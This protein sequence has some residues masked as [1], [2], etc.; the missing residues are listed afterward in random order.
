[1]STPDLDGIYSVLFDTIAE[2]L[3]IVDVNGK[4]VM[5]NPQACEMFL[6]DKDTIIGVQVEQLIPMPS[7]E[8]HVKLREGYVQDPHKRQMGKNLNLQAVKK[9]GTHFDVEISL[10]HFM[11]N[12]SAYVVAML[13]DITDRVAQQKQIRELNE[14][15]EQKV[16]E[17][18]RQVLESQKLYSAIAQNF[19]NGTINVF[20]RDLKYLFVEGLELQELGVAKEKLIGTSYLDKISQDIRPYIETELT[21]VFNG[22]AKIF[23]LEH[24]NQ[25]YKINAVPLQNGDSFI[26]KILVVE[27]NIT[28]QKLV[29]KQ[30][31]EALQKE[32]QLN[33]LKSRFVSMAS[34][35]FRTPLSTVLSSVSLIEKYIEKGDLD[36]TEKHI[37]RV[38]N[39]VSGLTEILNDFLSV[40]KLE[41]NKYEINPVDFDYK[42]FVEDIVEEMRTII[43]SGQE[44][45][46]TLDAEKTQISSDPKTL[47]NILYNLISNAIKY[48]DEGKKIYFSNQIKNG[49]L[50]ISVRD[51]GIGI[52]DDDQKELFGRFFRAKNATNIKGTGLGLNIVKKYV[53]MLN[54]DITFESVLNKGTTF[55]IIIPLN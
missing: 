9:D 55:R 1:M 46:L 54:G 37:D 7:R 16:E 18:T 3:L 45:E 13:T 6:C 31:E 11:S 34:H 49:Q 22:E 10:N 32:R 19:P 53:E 52:P 5:A 20:D 39:A 43:K 4:I 14:S 26:D 47:K 44:I 24:Q 17:R 51:E 29:E 25:V 2:G 12:G 41:S 36:K 30:R 48:S 35:E 27:E 50:E 21:E 33:E 40:E 23:E 42:E 15:L 8:K 28:A 38:K